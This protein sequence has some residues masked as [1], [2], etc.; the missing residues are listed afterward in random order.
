MK[1]VTNTGADALQ[2]LISPQKRLLDLIQR[3]NMN[4]HITGMIKFKFLWFS[5]FSPGLAV[6]IILRIRLHPPNSMDFVV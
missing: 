1:K 4:M 5:I 3:R 6:D 2:S